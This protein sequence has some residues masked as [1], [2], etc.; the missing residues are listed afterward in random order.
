MRINCPHCGARGVDEFVY[1]GDATVTR[2][3]ASTPSA[4]TDFV[5]FVYDRKNA[6]GPHEELW[7][8]AAGCHAWLVVSRNVSTHEISSV[9]LARD[10]ALRRN[11]AA[12][13]SV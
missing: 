1:N 10:V 4:M 13:E 8:H 2:P 9:E 5:K 12:K 11:S 7:Y 3:D 6:P